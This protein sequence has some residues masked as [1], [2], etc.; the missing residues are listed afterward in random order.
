MW[1]CAGALNFRVSWMGKDALFRW[2]YGF[3][4]RWLGG[5]PIIRHKRHN[6][7]QQMAQTFAEREK[8]IVGILPEGTRRKRDHWKS[9]FYYIAQQAGVPILL[10]F[11]DYRRKLCYMGPTLTPSGDVE[12][13]LKI[14]R[15]FY[16]DVR[17]KYPKNVSDIRF[18]TRKA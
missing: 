16:K 2:P 11:L 10:S 5:M 15:E 18:K 3:A 14:I 12:A 4:M 7:V 6:V 9:G 17:G 8:L 1:L 13:D